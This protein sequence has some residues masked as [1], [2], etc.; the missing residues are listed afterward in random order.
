MD[1][2]AITG[3]ACRFA[4]SEDLRAF[5]RRILNGDPAL[6]DAPD[7]EDYRF[8]A[9]D[10]KVFNRVTTLRGGYLRTQDFDEV[11]GLV[12]EFRAGKK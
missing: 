5:W 1:R 7:S 3:M 11:T 12:K 2:I 4:G 6:G 8:H 9:P 10:S